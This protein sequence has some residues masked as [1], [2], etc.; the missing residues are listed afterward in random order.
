MEEGHYVPYG[1]TCVFVSLVRIQLEQIFWVCCLPS[2]G[3]AVD[4]LSVAL[5]IE[6]QALLPNIMGWCFMIGQYS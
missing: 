2:N 1:L 4:T 6:L 3:I 5:N